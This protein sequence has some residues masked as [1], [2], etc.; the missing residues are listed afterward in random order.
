MALPACP[1]RVFAISC[2]L[3]LL[4]AT[5]LA[6][7]GAPGPQTPEQVADHLDRIVQPRFQQNAGRF[8]IDRVLVGGHDDVYGLDVTTARERAN[9]RLAKQARRPFV[10]AFLHCVHKPGQPVGAKAIEPLDKDFKPYVTVLAAAT[11]TQAGTEKL[12][13]WG[14]AHLERV[15]VPLVPQLRR[16]ENLEAQEGNWQIVMRPV[17]ALRAS[18]IG[19]HAGAKRGDTLGVMVYAVDR[20]VKQAPIKALRAGPP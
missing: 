13:D 2:T 11:K 18:C 20:N 16:G 8:G 9:L 10:V 1:R 3:L 12:Y 17:R 7:S 4:S 15:T 14:A 5:W 19:C 6:A